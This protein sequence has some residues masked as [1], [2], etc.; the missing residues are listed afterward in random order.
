[1]AT[2]HLR[3]YFFKK[4]N[5]Y[6]KGRPQG[7]AKQI[8]TIRRRILRVVQRRIFHEKDL[9]TVSTTDLLKFLA[10]I[11]PKDLGIKVTP[12]EI[13]YISNIPRDTPTLP[14][15]QRPLLGSAEVTETDGNGSDN[16]SKNVLCDQLH[17]PN[18]VGS[19]QQG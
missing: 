10:T 13:N 12:P 11:M 18:N 8:E 3:Q 7:S 2:E 4:G 19:E 9:H 5:T 1:M 6:G 17:T 14:Q 16:Q 15:E